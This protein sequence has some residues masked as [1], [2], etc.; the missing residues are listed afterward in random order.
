MAKRSSRAAQNR[1][2]EG[3]VEPL[4]GSMWRPSTEEG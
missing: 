3:V 1:L 4:F 2:H